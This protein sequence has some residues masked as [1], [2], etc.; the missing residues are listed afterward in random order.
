MNI[1]ELAHKPIGRLLWQY[2]APAVVGMLVMS[3]YNVI[4][5]IYIGR[6]V[7]P[8]A[9]SGLAITFPVMNLSAAMGVLIGAGASARTSIL[10]G[11]GDRQGAQ[12]ILGN[13]LILTLV[14]GTTYTLLFGYFIDEILLAFGASPATLPYA[15]DFMLWILPGML[16][17]NLCFSFNNIMRASGYPMR[18]MV[19]MILGAVLNIAIA[20]IFIFALDLG[21]K[22]A[23]IASD[24][25]MAISAAFVM[26]HF[27]RKES[28]VH[29]CRGI[30]RLK[31]P[32]VWSIITIGAAPSLV[33]AAACLI[34]MTVN[35]S[36]VK[37]GSDLD[38]GAAGIFITYTS[39]I[40]TFVVGLCMGMQPII[41][42]NF[43]AGKI[44]RLR[45]T[46]LLAC[47]TGSGICTA[48]CIFGLLFPRLIASVFTTDSHLIEVT[49]N[50]LQTALVMFWMVGFQ[51][52]STGFFQSIGRATESIV[53]S[54]SRQI[55]FL[56]PLL[57]ILPEYFGLNG[58]WMSFPISDTLA[59]MVTLALITWQFIKINRLTKPQMQ[60]S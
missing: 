58:V 19:T 21:I 2:S 38:V 22:G 41:G 11:A 51:V 39:L 14:I 1:D 3:L 7:G 43:G 25:S 15:R 37:Y 10:L 18:A 34:N 42:Y 50:G 47:A 53:L 56:Y 32:V 45:R 33:N 20:P 55:I 8:E 59:T 23:A 48:G 13:A 31:L 52:I 9:I 27:M 17:I 49:A 5:R 26:A 16:V 57:K 35:V 40:V 44:H 46:Y 29:F 36:L 54:L 12:T 24:I 6:G 60:S 30:Y 28:N 4:D